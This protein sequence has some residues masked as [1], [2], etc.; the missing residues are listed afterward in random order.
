MTPRF[1][2]EWCPH[3]ELV[4]GAEEATRSPEYL[5]AGSQIT[6]GSRDCGPANQETKMSVEIS[7]YV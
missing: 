7:L 4:P 5:C 1:L 2:T 3:R 6:V